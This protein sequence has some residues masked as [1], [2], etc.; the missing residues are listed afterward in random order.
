M[1]V[2][3]G[4]RNVIVAG[5]YKNLIVAGGDRN[6]I[7]AGAY[8]NVIVAGADRNVYNPMPKN[9][10]REIN[11]ALYV[12]ESFTKPSWA[13]ARGHLPPVSGSEFFICSSCSQTR[14]NV[15]VVPVV[16]STLQ[17]SIT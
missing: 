4:D 8:K 16:S 2:A 10:H 7:V 9:Y 15:L 11:H 12:G 5:A 1:I 3:G 14:Y 17:G 6:V 13:S